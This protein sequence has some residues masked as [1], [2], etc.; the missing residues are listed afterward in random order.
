MASDETIYGL[1][2]DFEWNFYIDIFVMRT[3]Q[4]LF[5][6]SVIYTKYVVLK[7]D[8]LILL[9]SGTILVHNVQVQLSHF[10]GSQ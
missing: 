7:S 1:N 9:S 3:K 6:I 8:T 4:M 5:S 2:A 10:N